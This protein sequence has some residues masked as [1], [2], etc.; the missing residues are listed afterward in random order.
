MSWTRESSADGSQTPSPEDSH[1]GS[2]SRS[3]TG[4]QLAGVDSTRV[5]TAPNTVAIV[6]KFAAS[7]G[8]ASAD[9]PAAPSTATAAAVVPELAEVIVKCPAVLA[10][11]AGDYS[12]R[13]APESSVGYLKELLS[14]GHPCRP[15]PLDQRLVFRG[16]LLNDRLHIA[17][18][19]QRERSQR[20]VIHM[21]LKSGDYQ[22]RSNVE[23]AAA[24]REAGCGGNGVAN[25]LEPR[26]SPTLQMHSSSP[27]GTVPVMASEAGSAFSSYHRTNSSVRASPSVSFASLPPLPTRTSPMSHYCGIVN[28]QGQV[29]YTDLSQAVLY[30]GYQFYLTRGSSLASSLSSGGGGGSEGSYSARRGHSAPQRRPAP[31]MANVPGPG[32]V[33][34]NIIVHRINIDLGAIFSFILRFG[35]VLLIFA[36]GGSATRIGILCILFGVLFL[37]QAGLFEFLGVQEIMRRLWAPIVRI[38]E[39]QQPP[40][41]E[42]GRPA[43]GPEQPPR[44]VDM[45]R[46]N[47]LFRLVEVITTFWLSLFPAEPPQLPPLVHNN[48]NGNNPVAAQA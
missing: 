23:K 42:N 31:R 13:L 5:E 38:R 4:S 47:P 44:Q 3:T 8:D 6:R 9:S 7:M 30:D 32:G 45:A 36:Q 27:L 1:G 46:M 28:G 33:R 2:G 35:I 16:Q 14:E 48:R 39:R 43:N 40:N 21:V 20:L 34:R 18:M 10:G 37:A 17:E 29:V 15:S 11:V 25:T 12:L 24:S 26:T 41:D 19:C 22:C